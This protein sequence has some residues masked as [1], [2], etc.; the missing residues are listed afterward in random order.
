MLPNG[1]WMASKEKAGGAEGS[2]VSRT[3]EPSGLSGGELDASW[4]D[5]AMLKGIGGTG[6]M[7]GTG[8]M[9][10]GARKGKADSLE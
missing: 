10:E 4:M 5:L 1:D 8:E 3:K 7:E 2:S 6:G 9:R